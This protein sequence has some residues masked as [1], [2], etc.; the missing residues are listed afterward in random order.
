M[1]DLIMMM[2]TARKSHSRFPGPFHSISLTVFLFDIFIL[3]KLKDIRQG[4]RETSKEATQ[5][6]TFCS[7]RKT[8]R[9]C[10]RIIHNAVQEERDAAGDDFFSSCSCFLLHLLLVHLLLPLPF[11]PS[12][13]LL[14]CS[15]TLTD[16]CLHLFLLFLSLTA[17]DS[18]QVFEKDTSQVSYNDRLRRKEK[19]ASL[20]YFAFHRKRNVSRFT[21][22]KNLA[23]TGK[24]ILQI[25][26]SLVC[27]TKIILKDQREGSREGK[28]EAECK[29]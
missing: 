27:Q 29:K 13:P 20:L 6:E 26:D 23:N 5:E 2:I 3:A 24:I 15:L 28:Q 16:F 14:S 22:R 19:V 7:D 9:R 1:Y 12:L 8:S 10:H 11:P 21:R 18:G 4:N 17:K 25:D